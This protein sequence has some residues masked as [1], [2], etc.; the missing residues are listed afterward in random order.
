MRFLDLDLDF[1]LNDATYYS[2]YDGIRAGSE[3]KPWSVSLVRRFLEDRCGLSHDTPV[4]GRTIESHDKVLDFWDMLIESGLLRAPFDVIHI[5]A[6]PDLWAGGGL[7][8]ASGFL[9]Y[10]SARALEDTGKKHVHAGNYLTF[11]IVRGWVAS[12]V[13]VHLG[14]QPN[15]FPGVNHVRGSGS[16]QLKKRGVGEA[17]V[18]DLPAA[19]AARSGVSFNVLPWQEFKTREAFDFMALSRSPNFT[20]RESDLLIPVVEGYIRPI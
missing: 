9:R 7:H 19:V 20:P 6:H 12:L 11:A 1:F 10:D 15:D 16:M 13:W 17:P 18:L 2:G 8:L 5:D 4:P 3:H 14:G